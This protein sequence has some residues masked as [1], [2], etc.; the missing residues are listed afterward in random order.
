MF[1]NLTK[2]ELRARIQAFNFHLCVCVCVNKNK[3]VKQYLLNQIAFC[4]LTTL[5]FEYVPSILLIHSKLLYKAFQN[6]LSQC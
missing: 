6:H 3:V 5:S 1:V 4:F 2:L